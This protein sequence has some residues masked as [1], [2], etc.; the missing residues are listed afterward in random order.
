MTMTR[1]EK[2]LPVPQNSL[3]IPSFDDPLTAERLLRPDLAAKY[4]AVTEALKLLAKAAGLAGSTD[5]LALGPDPESPLLHQLAGS[6]CV[7][8]VLRRSPEL[9][10]SKAAERVEAANPKWFSK[11]KY[12]KY[13][14]RIREQSRAKAVRVKRRGR[15]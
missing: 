9:S 11:A 8:F 7:D 12:M 14:N 10:R 3:G 15:S 5:H 2:D 13:T 6:A 4:D 1:P